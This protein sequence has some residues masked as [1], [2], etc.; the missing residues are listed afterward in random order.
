MILIIYG[1]L[2]SLIYC[3]F[4][5]P[6]WFGYFATMPV[7]I[8]PQTP[9]WNS[10]SETIKKNSGKIELYPPLKGRGSKIKDDCVCYSAPD[11]CFLQ[12]NFAFK[13]HS[14]NLFKISCIV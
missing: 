5:C 3:F 9:L 12:I 13:K 14:G 10:N 4:S 6:E 1:C 2:S 11:I 7:L 8:P